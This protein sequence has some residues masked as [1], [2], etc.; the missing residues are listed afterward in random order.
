MAAPTKFKAQNGGFSHTIL[1]ITFGFFSSNLQ[2]RVYYQHFKGH[3]FQQLG[4]PLTKD[5]SLAPTVLVTNM[6]AMSLYSESPE[7]GCKSRI[8]G[9][10][11]CSLLRIEHRSVATQKH[12]HGYY[13]VTNNSYNFLFKGNMLMPNI[14]AVFTTESLYIIFR[15]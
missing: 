11:S 13:E 8:L 6:A 2:S 12:H 3:L 15:L 14:A 4:F 9:T 5:F 10:F 7:I 1:K